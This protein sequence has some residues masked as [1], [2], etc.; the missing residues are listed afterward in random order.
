MGNAESEIE[1]FQC[2]EGF[3]AEPRFIPEFKGLPKPF[4]SWKGRE[5]DTEL[6]KS[7]FLKFEPR[8]KLPEDY[9]QFFFQRRS[10]VKKKGEGCNFEVTLK[11][12]SPLEGEG[13]GGGK[14]RRG[15]PPWA[16]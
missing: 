14:K 13:E 16:P 5:E 8:W 11:P 2:P 1:F 10:M 7:L 3:L 4:G 12:P 6:L 15:A 9:S